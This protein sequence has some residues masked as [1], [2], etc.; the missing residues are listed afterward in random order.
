MDILRC[1]SCEGFGWS[2]DDLSGE[3]EDCEWCGGIGYVYHQN[4][5][6]QKIPQSDMEKPE[7][8]ARLEALEAERMREIGYSGEAKKP[9]QQE[10]RKGTK[11][12]MNPYEQD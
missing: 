5:L 10:F 6:D 8:A 11:G 2:E 7:I 12:G 3:A 1:P 9:W 4:G